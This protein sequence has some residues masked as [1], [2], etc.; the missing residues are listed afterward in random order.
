MEKLRP[1]EHRFQG[2][3]FY[4][5]VPANEN[6][7]GA[8]LGPGYWALHTLS[9]VPY[10]RV[11]IG[12]SGARTLTWGEQLEIPEGR[13]GQVQNVS[14]HAGD[15]IFADCSWS[16]TPTKPARITI[17]A[18]FTLTQLAGEDVG[19][20]LET[21]WVDTRGARRVYLAVHPTQTANFTYTV[22]QE[23]P[24]RGLGV[25]PTGAASKLGGVVTMNRAVVGPLQMWPLG[26]G[27]SEYLDPAGKT[28]PE[29]RPMSLLDRARVRIGN[30]AINALGIDDH[31]DAFYVI[32]Y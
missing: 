18:P 5:D 10:V 13:F 8:L 12:A 17:A 15:I 22:L 24:T 29:L 11:G 27:S 4:K 23:G 25:S 21:D 2:E 31:T 30:A 1:P 16:A 20:I 26:F 6:A 9:S 19:F 28:V 32:E 14:F 7:G 3:T